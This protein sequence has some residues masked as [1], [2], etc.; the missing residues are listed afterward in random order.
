MSSVRRRLLIA[1][2]ILSVGLAT[3]GVFLPLLPTTPFLLLAAACFIRSSPRLYQWLIHHKWF[4]SYL[5]N[6]WEHRAIPRRTKVVIIILLWGTLLYSI[7]GIVK[8]WWIRICL[9]A[10][11]TGVTL[12]VLRLKTLA[13]S[14]KSENSTFH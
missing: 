1:A 5:R 9:V 4:G 8:L 14:P 6:Y 7:V 3:A 13:P 11:G 2:G 12:H 10:I